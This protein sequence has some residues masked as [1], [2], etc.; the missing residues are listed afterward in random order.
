MRLFGSVAR[1]E[2]REGSDVDLCVDMPITFRGVIGLQQY[3]EDE[4]ACQVDLVCVR[5]KMN[6]YLKQ[7]I[8]KDGI[9]II[10]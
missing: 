10:R 3:L 6:P 2:Q 1:N 4:L 5:D 7:Q 8:E 9:Y